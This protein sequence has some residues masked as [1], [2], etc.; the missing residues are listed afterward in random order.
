LT[1]ASCSAAISRSARLVP[2]EEGVA[3]APAAELGVEE[4]HL[5]VDVGSGGLGIPPTRL[6]PA[7]VASFSATRKSRAFLAPVEVLVG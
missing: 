3:D 4:G 2:V 5:P 7:G 6:L 1:S